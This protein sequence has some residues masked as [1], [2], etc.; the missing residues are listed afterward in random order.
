LYKS[1]IVIE[2]FSPEQQALVAQ[3]FAQAFTA[4]MRVAMYAA[5]VGLVV[6]AATW[7]RW[8]PEMGERGVMVRPGDGGRG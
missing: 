2:T 6:S 1:P 4:Q 5:A 8:P 3:V 7:E